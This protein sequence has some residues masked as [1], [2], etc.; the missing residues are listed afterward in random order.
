MN[1]P[2]RFNLL[3]AAMPV[4][5]ITPILIQPGET[6]DSE[7]DHSCKWLFSVCKTQYN[8]IVLQDKTME[9]KRNI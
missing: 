9:N 4:N 7:P 8:N 6:V 3:S 2:D 5:R 1:I